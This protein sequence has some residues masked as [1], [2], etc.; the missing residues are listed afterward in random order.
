[1]F[2]MGTKKA[3]YCLCLPI[4]RSPIVNKYREGLLKRNWPRCTGCE[5]DFYQLVGESLSNSKY[6]TH[7]VKEVVNLP[8]AMVHAIHSLRLSLQTKALDG[9]RFRTKEIPTQRELALCVDSFGQ[10]N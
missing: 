7:R 6:T 8:Q 1:M 2:K 3:F 9:G 4:Q 10:K 5:M